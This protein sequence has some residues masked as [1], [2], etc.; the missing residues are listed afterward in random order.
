MLLQMFI[1]LPVRGCERHHYNSNQRIFL[2]LYLEWF[3]PVSIMFLLN[4]IGCEIITGYCL[5]EYVT[6]TGGTML[7]LKYS[8]ACR[9]PNWIDCPHVHTLFPST[10]STLSNALT[11]LSWWNPVLQISRE[12]FLSLAFL[13]SNCWY[14]FKCQ[15]A[16]QNS[17]NVH[18]KL[19]LK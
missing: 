15:E 8:G 10:R 13:H 16:G 4:P 12:L 2:C 9:L 14:Y 6:V 7:H 18:W 5:I 19:F 11:P 3:L 17:E 1:N